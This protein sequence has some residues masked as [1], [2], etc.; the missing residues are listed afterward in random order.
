VERLA[1]LTDEGD[2]NSNLKKEQQVF[3]LTV[4]LGNNEESLKKALELWWDC[5]FA[6][7]GQPGLR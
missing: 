1:H 5:T 6:T 3:T 4:N 7:V 2:G